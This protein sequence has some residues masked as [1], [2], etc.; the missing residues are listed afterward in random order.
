ML[1]NAM[2]LI[3]IF[4]HEVLFAS[5]LL[6]LFLKYCFQCYI[7]INGSNWCISFFLL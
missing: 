6:L 1:N 7:C 5:E 2:S 4:T 3:D